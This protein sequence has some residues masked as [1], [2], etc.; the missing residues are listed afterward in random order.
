MTANEI[1]SSAKRFGS[2]TVGTSNAGEA[3]FPAQENTK[4]AAQVAGFRIAFE[5]TALKAKRSGK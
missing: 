1:F 2:I 5:S 3:E 4:V